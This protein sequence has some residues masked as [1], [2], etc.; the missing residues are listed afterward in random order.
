MTPPKGTC[1]GIPFAFFCALIFW[2]LV[3]LCVKGCASEFHT[4]HTERQSR[5]ENNEINGPNF[6]RFYE[7]TN[8][9][10]LTE[11]AVGIGA[12]PIPASHTLSRGEIRLWK[13]SGFVGRCASV[14]EACS[15]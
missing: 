13:Q 12:L 10:W 5:Q 15:N 2:F 6:G 4:A 1:A 8:R 3:G 7:V 11:E 14:V 9:G